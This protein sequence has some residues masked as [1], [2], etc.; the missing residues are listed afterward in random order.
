M[1]KMIL[2]GLRTIRKNQGLTLKELSIMTGI[3]VTYLNELEL[4]YKANPSEDKINVLIKTLNVS[5]KQLVK[6]RY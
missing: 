1:L 3:S 4:L 2:T 5:K 6:E